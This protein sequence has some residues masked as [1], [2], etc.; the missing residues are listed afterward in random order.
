[1]CSLVVCDKYFTVYMCHMVTGY[2]G[3]Y[4]HNPFSSRFSLIRHTPQVL[5][6]GLTPGSADGSDLDPALSTRALSLHF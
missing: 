2:M 1:M 4:T 3:M 6:W 5:M